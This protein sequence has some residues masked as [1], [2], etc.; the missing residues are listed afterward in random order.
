MSASYIQNLFADRLGG[1]N[2]GK[3]TALYKFEKI[4]RAKATAL[5]TRP[6]LSLI[7]M[8][9]G[10]PDEM[11][12]PQVIATLQKE[13]EKPENK[14]YAD[15]GCLDFQVA[16]ARYM[17]RLFR[18]TLD[19]NTE[20][21]HSIGSKS[22][23]AL[24]PTC[25]INPGDT[26]LVTV[27]GYPIFGTHVRYYGGNLYPL[28][29]LQQ[30]HFL[31]DLEKIPS[32]ALKKAKILLLNYPNNPTGA[33]ASFEFF[34]K[35]VTFAKTNQLMI[36]HDAAYSALTFH[37]EF[38]SVLQVEGAKDIAIELHSLSKGFNMT[39]WRLGW[40]CGNASLIKAYGEVKDNTDSGQFLAIQKAGCTALENSDIAEQMALKYSRRMDLLI[41][42]LCKIGFPAEKPKGGFFLYVTA[43]KW[44]QSAEGKRTSFDS[45]EAFSEWLLRETLISTVPWDEAGAFVRFAVTFNACGEV[46][47]R[48]IVNAV[49]ERLKGYQLGF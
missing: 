44:A 19:P 16:V 22:A 34:Q 5:Q 21:L 42:I 43:P 28:P 38:L 36:V 27:P 26:V 1:Q 6:D 25:F 40:I 14:G 47:E 17:R 9:V 29:L 2:Y 8:G 32:S 13:A 18:V 48:K 20:I 33:V 15:K 11:A 23:L 41:E 12:F 10:E 30:N 35:A 45:A 31:P 37:R 7:D 49:E 3:S 39:G 24:L 4:K 46:E